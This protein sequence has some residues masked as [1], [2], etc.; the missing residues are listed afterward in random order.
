MIDAFHITRLAQPQLPRTYQCVIRHL[1]SCHV[2]A[3]PPNG[4]HTSIQI[5]YQDTVH[6]QYLIYLL[7]PQTPD[8]SPYLDPDKTGREKMNKKKYQAWQFVF[9]LQD[10]EH[11]TER[12]ACYLSCTCSF[13]QLATAG[14]CLGVY[15][16]YDTGHRMA[17]RSA[18]T[19]C[20]FIAATI[21][22]PGKSG[23]IGKTGKTDKTGSRRMRP[24]LAR[25]LSGHPSIC[26]LFQK[27]GLPR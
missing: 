7:Y 24:R 3:A 14:C 13:Q 8:H 25:G 12:T 5:I 6:Q 19:P 4:Q 16:C 21:C 23:K 22:S 17:Y 10:Q 26:P 27:E 18:A 2:I 15:H 1:V 9:V 11:E 20:H